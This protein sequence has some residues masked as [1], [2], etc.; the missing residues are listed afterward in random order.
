MMPREGYVNFRVTEANGPLLDALCRHLLTDPKNHGAR[1]DALN[2]A[3]RHTVAEL[4]LAEKTEDAQDDDDV[5]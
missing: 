3:L 5:E 2:F 1:V 4:R